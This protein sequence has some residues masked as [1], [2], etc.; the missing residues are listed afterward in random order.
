MVF[1]WRML[2]FIFAVFLSGCSPKSE[3]ESRSHEIKGGHNL[4]GYV[5]KI[6]K[7][8]LYLSVTPVKEG[9]Q[10][11]QAAEPSQKSSMK[12][13]WIEYD[14]TK[15]FQVGNKVYIWKGDSNPEAFQVL[16]VN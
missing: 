5:L 11:S 3:T 14:R 2:I 13:I 12:K 16:K 9:Y 7:D 15:E 1:K 6:E 10:E 4:E 8:R